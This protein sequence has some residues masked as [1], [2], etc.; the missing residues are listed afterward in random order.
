M[1]SKKLDREFLKPQI[2]LHGV[3]GGWMG[4]GSGLVVAGGSVQ[5]LLDPCM[6][7]NVSL[8]ENGNYGWM[9]KFIFYLKP[10]IG[11]FRLYID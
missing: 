3:F 2:N 10:H 9:C 6:K 11:Y 4:D 8:V 5:F 1:K 7:F